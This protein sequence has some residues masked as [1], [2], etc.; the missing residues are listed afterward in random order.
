MT[1][2]DSSESGL[3]S[4]R[5]LGADRFDPVRFHHLEVLA[6]RASAHQGQVKQLLD[7]KLAHALAAFKER[8]EQ[9][10]TQA[11]HAVD[12][13]APQYPQAAADLQR[14]LQRGDVAAAKQGLAKLNNRPHGTPLGELTRCLAQHRSPEAETR[15][16]G[17]AGLRRTPASTQFFRATWAKIS[18]DKRV[19]QALDQA[20]K[21]A[22]PINSHLLV[23]RSLALMRD[24]SPDYLNRL[25]AYVDTLLGLD[26]LDQQ[27]SALPRKPPDIE[28]AKKKKSRPARG[29]SR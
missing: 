20:P 7:G 14:L 10:Q 19:T 6:R 26:G 29:Q 24:I 3:E 12:Q 13:V 25:T 28:I 9:A 16:S 5:Q 23:L 17:H 15:S 21:N 8:F 18:V 1:E 22:G 27:K 4:L 11:R 2:S